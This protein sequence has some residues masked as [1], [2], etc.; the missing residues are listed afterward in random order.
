MNL[1]RE[2]TVGG[3]RKCSSG[4]SDL[5][6]EFPNCMKLQHC[7]K[8]CQCMLLNSQKSPSWTKCHPK[9]NNQ[10]IPQAIDPNSNCSILVIEVYGW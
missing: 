1:L 9:K 8:L 4:I 6:S 7:L 3:V 10:E 2:P 5:F